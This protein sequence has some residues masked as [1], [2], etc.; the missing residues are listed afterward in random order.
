MKKCKRCNAFLTDETTMCP[1]CGNSAFINENEINTENAQFDKS[2]NIDTSYNGQNV[3]YSYPTSPNVHQFPPMEAAAPEGSVN[4]WLVALS[5][6]IPLAGIIIYFVQKNDNRKNAKACGK[7]ALIV[8]LIEIILSALFTIL[9]L[10]VGTKAISEINSNFDDVKIIT[11]AEEFENS[12]TDGSEKEDKN[13]ESLGNDECGYVTLSDNNWT[14][15]TEG[16]SGLPSGA[17]MYKNEGSYLLMSPCGVDV[18]DFDFSTQKDLVNA[19]FSSS[20]NGVG[21]LKSKVPL[22]YENGNTYIKAAYGSLNGAQLYMM[23]YVTPSTDDVQII[24]L[25]SNDMSFDEFKECVGEILSTN[26]FFNKTVQSN[27]ENSFVQDI[28]E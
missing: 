27:S 22:D 11:D 7:A 28:N 16:V 26:S 17:V 3:N 19:T 5:V 1:Y 9:M 2:K 24:T 14:E 4:G 15:T 20:M 8:I 12:L 13:S 25:T 18:S 10:S 6:I 21:D 23:A